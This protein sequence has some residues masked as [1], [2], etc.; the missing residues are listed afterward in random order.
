M[1]AL[2]A[3][4]TVL[5]LA[6]PWV[7]YW[8][9]TKGTTT[10][11]GFVLIAWLVLR[12]IPSWVAAR[13]EQKKAT[14]VL[15]A[16]GLTFAIVGMVLRSG[17]LFRLVPTFTNF[18]FAATFF[19]SLRSTPMIEHFARMVKPELPPAE[20]AYC[21][22][23]TKVWGAYTAAIGI[24]GA[25]LAAFA[26]VHV[27]ATYAGGVAYGLVGALFAVEYVVRKAK[28]RDFGPN[29]LDALLRRVFPPAS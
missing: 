5:V 6:S 17:F 3:A 22:T 26:P 9:L 24:V 18:G 21:R 14:L 28:F 8:T 4:S 27:W 12:T 25:V 29:R 19:W 1:S 10:V 15:P 2:R 20:V 23:L 7:L 13:P 11:A 16:V